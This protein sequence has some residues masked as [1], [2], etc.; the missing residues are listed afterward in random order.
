[1]KIHIVSNP[2]NG[3]TY[4]ASMFHSTLQPDSP[5][6]NEPFMGSYSK[7]ERD[8]V[9]AQF[10]EIMDNLEKTDCVLKSHL[11]H[12]ETLTELELLERFQA[13]EFDRTYT[14]HRRD[15]L[16][17]I[18][19]LCVARHSGQ[20]YEEFDIVPVRIDPKQ[21]EVEMLCG[22]QR[23]CDLIDNKYQLNVDGVLY[24]EDLSWNFV[25]DVNKFSEFDVTA[26]HY[27][28]GRAQKFSPKHKSII[29]YEEVTTRG[30]EVLQT[31][32]H[33]QVEWHLGCYYLKD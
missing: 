30:H 8:N 24:F 7:E 13:I 23:V 21:L 16:N 26:A 1:M 18:L 33:P 10:V 29:N 9:R 25:K 3:S 4:A 22:W 2:R 31:L 15:F 6:Y 17:S 20:W 11:F 14:L 28:W 19:S 12:Y 27:E 32:T 5:L